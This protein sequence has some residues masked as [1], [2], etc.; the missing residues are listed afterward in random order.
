MFRDGTHPPF[1]YFLHKRDF[2]VLG[3]CYNGGNLVW[4]RGIRYAAEDDV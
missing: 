1:H 3:G 4:G 2:G